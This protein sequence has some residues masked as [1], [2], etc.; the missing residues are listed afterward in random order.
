MNVRMLILALVT[1]TIAC[2]DSDNA[3]QQDSQKVLIDSLFKEVMDGHDVAMPKMGKIKRGIDQV[4][5]SLDSLGKISANKVDTAYRRTLL[6]LKEELE[7]A[8]MSMDKWMTEFVLDSASNNPEARIKYLESEKSKV[9]KVRDNVLN[10]LQRADSL[11][12]N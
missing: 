10:S 9:T 1:I 8:D 4:Q 12:K 11:F 7:Y 5:K 6:S 2:N 3:K